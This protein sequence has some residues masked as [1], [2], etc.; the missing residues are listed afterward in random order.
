M[1][2]TALLLTAAILASPISAPGA[3]TPAY[4][5]ALDHTTP[6]DGDTLRTAPDRVELVF[7]G[8]IENGGT[9][10]SLIL[11]DGSARELEFSTTG[12]QT[13]TVSASLP[14]LDR[15]GY[16]IEWRVLSPDGHPLEGTFVFYVEGGSEGTGESGGTDDGGSG[17]E[18]REAGSAGDTAGIATPSGGDGRG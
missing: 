4:H 1:G 10:V 17:A 6:A 5:T 18:A 16:R 15:G 12:E 11:A 14:A 9:S 3:A 7:T 13:P 2:S 8:P